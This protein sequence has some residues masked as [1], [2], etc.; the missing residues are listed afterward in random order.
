MSETPQCDCQD[1][2]CVHTLSVSEPQWRGP[3]THRSARLDETQEKTWPP[4]DLE[5]KAP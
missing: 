5:T 3:G 1:Q 4:G 2:P